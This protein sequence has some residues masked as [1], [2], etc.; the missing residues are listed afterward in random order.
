MVSA[1]THLS[2]SVDSLRSVAAS[3]TLT[4]VAISHLMEVNDAA[5]AGMSRAIAKAPL[6]Y[7]CNVV[8]GVSSWRAARRAL[9]RTTRAALLI[10]I[11]ALDTA[12]ISAPTLNGSRMFFP[13]N[14]AANAGGSTEK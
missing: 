6:R 8:G 2:W 7:H 1:W 11:D 4:S 12:S 5:A 9:F 10:V 13:A 3:A 14:C